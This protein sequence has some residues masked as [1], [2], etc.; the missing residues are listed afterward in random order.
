MIRIGWFSTARG[1]TSRALLAA[2]VEAIRDGRVDAEIA[3]VFCSREDG[4]S[5]ETD[6]FLAQVRGYGIPL[7]TRSFEAARQAAGAK[8]MGFGRSGFAPWRQAYDAEIADLLAPYRADVALQAGYMLV[9]SPGLCERIHAINLHPAAPGGPAGTWQQ[10]I[11]Q[12]IDQ[13]ATGSGVYMHLVTP[14]LD[15]GPV[16]TYCRYPLDTPEFAAAWAAVG[17]RTSEDLKA[18]DG[19]DLPLFQQ[20]RAAGVRREVP[21][22]IATLAALGSG[23]V[24]VLHS[25]P[26][27]A[28][29]QPSGP[30]DLTLTIEA[31]LGHTV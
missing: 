26:A 21:L 27:G 13:R 24:R 9:W 10:V 12:L 8:G 5:P 1:A 6:Q 16:V 25:G 31:E 29:G 30:L 11:W 28:D 19:E 4:E 15:Q 18:T 7:V 17:E 14:S 23:Q 20:I 22:I 3:Y 2:A